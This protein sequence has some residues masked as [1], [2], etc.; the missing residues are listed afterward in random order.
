MFLGS[1]SGVLASDFLGT[2]RMIELMFRFRMDRL[3]GSFFEFSLFLVFDFL[4]SDVAGALPGLKRILMV[5]FFAFGGVMKE[6]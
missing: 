1:F 2:L 3:G 5:M 4:V 6:R